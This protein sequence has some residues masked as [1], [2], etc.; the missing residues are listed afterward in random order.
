[1]GFFTNDAEVIRLGRVFFVTIA[2]T[3]PIMALGFA[4]GGALRGGGEPMPPFIYGSI[5]E[6]LVVIGAGFIFAVPLGMGF[7]GI[8]LG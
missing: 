5:S 6:L 1:M 7:G 4:L 3:E 2:I 8:A